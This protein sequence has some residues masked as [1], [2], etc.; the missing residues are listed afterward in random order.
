MRKFNLIEEKWIPVRFL[1]G[2][3]DELGIR[4]TL[5][6]AREISAIEDTSPLVVAALHRFLLAVL[7][8]ALQGPTDIEQA[9]KVFKEGIPAKQ[10]QAYLE[11]MS[12]RFWL[13]DER[14]PFGQIPD[15]KPKEWKAWTKIAA[16]HNA[17]NAKVLFDH[18]DIENPGTISYAAAARW[19]LAA[20]TFDLAVAKS[21]VIQP[22]DAPSARALFFIVLGHN[23]HDTLC[24]NLRPRAKHLCR[25]DL[26]IWERNP[27]TINELKSGRRRAAMGYADYYTWRSRTV[28]LE[29]GKGD[30]IQRLGFA[31]GVR[32]SGD[33]E[34]IDPMVCYEANPKLGFMAKKL[35]EE[36]QFWREFDSLLPGGEDK[37]PLVL[38]NAIELCRPAK[39][40]WPRGILVCG[41]KTKRGQAKVD[42][43]RYSLFALPKAL[44]ETSRVRSFIH[45][46]L[47]IAEESGKSL[48]SAFW[49]FNR[50]LLFR[51]PEKK[52]EELTRE[53]KT[54]IW[55]MVDGM[56][57]VQVYWSSLEV[58]FHR[59]LRL[60]NHEEDSEVVRASW[61]EGVRG[62]L[63]S[64]WDQ[65]AAAVI[66]GGDVWAI[67][68]L[69][70]A[71]TIV[72]NKAKG[73]SEEIEKLKPPLKE[74]I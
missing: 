32:I 22:L 14:Y 69:V 29:N 20:Q 65:H 72:Q 8:R 53:E 50:H 57:P 62:A 18:I 51:N 27:E 70:K 4:D 40:R 42:F 52:D 49:I 74:V 3:R 55:S 71:E 56:A 15:F 21:E 48:R 2:S 39:D 54:D 6:R 10:I 64:A 33:D 28:V 30:S 31:S 46:I 60:Y 12:P 35:R 5:L 73:L 41:Q 37:I 67:R 59:V 19:L 13:F 34:F 11:E 7:Y 16:E 66:S 25:A 26:A 45:S 63:K 38:E 23:L 47:E 68:A 44:S 24:F 1:D 43:W 9:K 61:L 58:D 36:K 17:D